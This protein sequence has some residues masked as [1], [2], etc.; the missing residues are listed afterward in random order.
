MMEVAFARRRSSCS[1]S[2]FSH[3]GMR[4]AFFGQSVAPKFLER[5][6]R[7]QPQATPSRRARTRMHACVRRH[8]AARPH[9]RGRGRHAESPCS[10][11]RTPPCM[12]CAGRL[13]M[14]GTYQPASDLPTRRARECLLNIA[15]CR[16]CTRQCRAA[17]TP[18]RCKKPPLKWRS[19][20]PF[21]LTLGGAPPPSATCR[22]GSLRRARP[23]S[24]SGSRSSCSALQTGALGGCGGCGFQGRRPMHVPIGSWTKFVQM[25]A[26][27]PG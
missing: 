8:R 14:A 10:L 7:N 24:A 9:A 5:G 18:K 23:Q 22:C 19:G 11:K 26:Q 20:R 17:A 3:S 21:R 25:E 4:C 6:A 15:S 27:R 1:S 13:S 16:S 12:D 2:R